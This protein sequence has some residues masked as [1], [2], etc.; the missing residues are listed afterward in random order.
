MKQSYGK[1]WSKIK[2]D[3]TEEEKLASN[4]VGSAGTKKRAG[5]KKTRR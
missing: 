4:K 3:E 1:N 2:K 5:N